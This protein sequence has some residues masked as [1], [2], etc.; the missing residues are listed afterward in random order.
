MDE[1]GWMW[2]NVWGGDRPTFFKK[3]QINQ[4]SSSEKKLDVKKMVSTM[5]YQKYHTP[6]NFACLQLQM[7]NSTF[8]TLKFQT[9][10]KNFTYPKLQTLNKHIS[11]PFPKVKELLPWGSEFFCHS[12]ENVALPAQDMLH[13]LIWCVRSTAMQQFFGTALPCE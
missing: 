2:L 9:P 13:T 10:Q 7:T 8:G 11:I 12:S 1:C 4:L 6:N 5:T 3:P